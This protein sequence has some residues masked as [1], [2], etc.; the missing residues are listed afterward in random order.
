[1]PNWSI[2]STKDWLRQL[3]VWHTAQYQEIQRAALA[4][5][6]GL[7]PK[8]YSRPFPGSPQSTTV[9]VGGEPGSP[10]PTPGT[11]MSTPQQ[12]PAPTPRAPDQTTPPAP[13]PKPGTPVW[14]TALL[15]AGS[16]LVGLAG[17]GALGFLQRTAT[18]PAPTQAGARSPAVEPIH[19]KLA[20][21]RLG[22]DGE[23]EVQGPDGSWKKVKDLT[24]TAREG[25]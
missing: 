9:I 3:L 5:A 15:T 23:W 6:N 18:A 11:P 12:G 21:W 1:M 19:L 13:P 7:D 2:E 24:G 14:L 17:P 10:Q 4:K 16:L 22:P 25:K 20:A 8:E